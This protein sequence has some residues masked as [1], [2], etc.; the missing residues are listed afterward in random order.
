MF[1]L[2][3]NLKECNPTKLPNWVKINKHR[4]NVIKNVVQ[5]ARKIIYKLGNSMLVLFILINHTN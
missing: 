4:S 1:E 5:N 3:N 2:Q